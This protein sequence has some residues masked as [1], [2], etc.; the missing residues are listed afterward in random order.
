MFHKRSAVIN[1]IYSGQLLCFI[2]IVV[3]L[4]LT[5]FHLQQ[6]DTGYKNYPFHKEPTSYNQISFSSLECFA[7]ESIFSVIIKRSSLQKRE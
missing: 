5:I 1:S 2:V 4:L 3:S 7:N 6:N